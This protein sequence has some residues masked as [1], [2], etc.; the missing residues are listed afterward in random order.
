[1][2]E[3]FGFDGIITE[4]DNRDLFDELIDLSAPPCFPID[5]EELDPETF[6]LAVAAYL[7]Y[8]GVRED[9]DA[10][11]FCT[12]SELINPN[13]VTADYAVHCASKY[14]N[15]KADLFTNYN[16]DRKTKYSDIVRAMGDIFTSY[17]GTRDDFYKYFPS[18]ML[19]DH[20]SSEVSSFMT[21]YR[22]RK[23]HNHPLF[24]LAICIYTS[25]RFRTT[26]KEAVSAMHRKYHTY[27][28]GACDYFDVIN[29]AMLLVDNCLSYG[30]VKL[31]SSMTIIWHIFLEISRHYD[32]FDDMKC[33]V[34]PDKNYGDD[35]D[36]DELIDENNTGTLDFGYMPNSGYDDSWASVFSN[37]AECDDMFDDE[38]D[39]EYDDEYDDDEI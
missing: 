33:D 19:L 4:E 2:N 32:D 16:N 14:I 34:R 7:C 30:S 37:A 3:K 6:I 11:L 5:D 23:Y 28:C 26:K 18:R 12:I 15:D 9:I 35:I 22:E 21:E 31:F 27:I 25:L 10:F 1:M 20:F 38:F 36:F 29:D 24:A 17:A 8:N 39:D 13:I